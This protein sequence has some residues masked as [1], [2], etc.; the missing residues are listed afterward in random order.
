[1]LVSQSCLS[2]CNPMDCS[3]PGSSVRGI[4]QAGIQEWIATPFSRGS[5]WPRD[6]TWVSCIAGGFFTVWAPRGAFLLEGSLL[7]Y[8]VMVSAIGQDESAICIHISPPSCLFLPPTKGKSTETQWQWGT[9]IPLLYRWTAHPGKI[10]KETQALNDTLDQ[11]DLIDLCWTFRPKAAEYTFFSSHSPGFLTVVP[12]SRSQVSGSSPIQHTSQHSAA[13]L[14]LVSCLSWAQ[15]G[16]SLPEKKRQRGAGMAQTSH[17]QAVNSHN[18][19]WCILAVGTCACV[20]P[21]PALWDPVDRSP[22]GSSVHGILQAWILEWIAIS[23]S[24]ESSQAR[25][26]THISC[27]SCIGRWFLYQWA[28]WE[29]LLAVGSHC[30]CCN[31]HFFFFFSLSVFV[32]DRVHNEKVHKAKKNAKDPKVKSSFLSAMVRLNLPWCYLLF[33]INFF[34]EA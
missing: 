26:W 30:K 17:T 2:L 31:P 13:A 22:P 18:P 24:R 28:T 11:I 10:N 3:P 12:Q 33:F 25:D 19:S 29:S 4:Q 15:E 7:S 14:R 23:S 9:L 1:M 8:V 5:S 27:V 6:W 21:C 34:V 20:Q 16:S 32:L